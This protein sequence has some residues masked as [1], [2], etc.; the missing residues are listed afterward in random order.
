MTLPNNVNHL[1]LDLETHLNL[2]E[3][4]NLRSSV[5]TSAFLQ[6]WL[7]FPVLLFSSK[8]VSGS[9]RTPTSHRFHLPKAFSSRFLGQTHSWINV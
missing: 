2:K 5:S 7:S 8:A 9:S 1:T 3:S 6:M 4:L